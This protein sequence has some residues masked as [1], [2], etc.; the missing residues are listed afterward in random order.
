MKEEELV[1]SFFL[2]INRIKIEIEHENSCLYSMYVSM[3]H[4]FRN[5]RTNNCMCHCAW[6]SWRT[7]RNVKFL[8][9]MCL[10]RNTSI[11]C[12]MHT[13]YFILFFV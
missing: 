10:E 13:A 9:R 12:L 3:S 1:F 5:I 2:A 6:I 7:A 11:L 4:R 8:C